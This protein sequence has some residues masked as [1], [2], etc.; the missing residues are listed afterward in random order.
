M[1]NKKIIKKS[2]LIFG[3][4]TAPTIIIGGYFLL[5]GSDPYKI[6]WRAPISCSPQGFV[7]TYKASVNQGA[8]VLILPGFTHKPGIEEAYSTDINI[9]KEI[10]TIF[11]DD[12]LSAEKKN[13]KAIERV[14]S[15]SYRTDI[16][17][18]QTGISAAWLLNQNQDYFGDELTYGAWGAAN[19]SSVMSFLGGFQQGIDWFNSVVLPLLNAQGIIPNNGG[20]KFIPVKQ[21]KGVVGGDVSGSFAEGDGTKFAKLYLHKGADLLFPVSGPQVWS[22]QTEILSQ[23]AKCIL[24]GVDSPTENDPRNKNMIGKGRKVGNGKVVQFSSVKKLDLSIFKMLVII[25]N[26]NILPTQNELDKMNFPLGFN[27]VSD[28]NGFVNSQNIGGFGFHSIGDYE[29]KS[30]G[31]SGEGLNYYNEVINLIKI[32]PLKTINFDNKKIMFYIGSEDDKYSYSNLQIDIIDFKKLKDKKTGE[33]IFNNFNSLSK[34]GL[35]TKNN[36]KE[37]KTFKI[38]VSTPTSVLIDGSFSQACYIGLYLYFK[39]MGI[40]IPKLNG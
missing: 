18:F 31:A 9:F 37:K 19:F 7:E 3:I 11:I 29:N 20:I 40:N 26:G 2:F 30:V 32:D 10:G 22:S 28:Y 25:N 13:Q 6:F 36:Q 27:K 17:S 21:I 1:I 8:K 35:I 33:Y 12:T 5:N 24:I 38:I 15:I 34:K 16:G 14:S 23:K 39:A 4:I